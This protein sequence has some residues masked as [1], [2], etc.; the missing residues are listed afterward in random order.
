MLLGLALSLSGK[1]RG[2]KFIPIFLCKSDGTVFVTAD[3]KVL[4]RGYVQR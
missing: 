2:G 3:G 1:G 4:V